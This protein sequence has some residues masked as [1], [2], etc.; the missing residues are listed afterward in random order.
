MIPVLWIQLYNRYLA[1]MFDHHFE[2][3]W[4]SVNPLGDLMNEVFV[5][6]QAECLALLAFILFLPMSPIFPVQLDSSRV[7]IDQTL[8]G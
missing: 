7:N 5:I 2:Y 1:Y 6:Y 4:L 3:L 8:T